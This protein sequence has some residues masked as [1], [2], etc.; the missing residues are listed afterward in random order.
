MTPHP[1]WYTGGCYW[2]GKRDCDHCRACGK[3]LTDEDKTQRG[4]HQ[5]DRCIPC[6]EEYLSETYPE[7]T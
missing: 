5:A 3:T 7:V 6:E 4:V 2:C 1:N